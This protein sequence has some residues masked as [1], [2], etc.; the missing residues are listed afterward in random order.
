LIFGYPGEEEKHR[1]ET[2]SVM[3]EIAEQFDNVSF[4]PNIFTPYPG[5]PIWPELRSM[6]LEEPASLV[7]W[8]DIDL[9]VTRLPWLQGRPLRTLQRSMSYFLLNNQINK[10]RR[11]TQSRVAISA[12][13]AIRKLLHWRFQHY[14]FNYPLELWFAA[15]RTWLT[16]RRSLLTGEPLSRELAKAR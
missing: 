8:A 13:E 3:G 14:A 1:K 9:G 7:D 12:L 2:L 16:V 15:T 10:Q 6:G 11:R 4:S 5:I